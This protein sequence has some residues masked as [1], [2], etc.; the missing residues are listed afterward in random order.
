MKA[1]LVTRTC[2]S[3][4]SL[5]DH[6]PKERINS[7]TENANRKTKVLKTQPRREFLTWMENLFGNARK[8]FAYNLQSTICKIQNRCLAGRSHLTINRNGAWDPQL[9]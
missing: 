8:T 5:Q 4:L 9:T 7:C 2:V 1:S 6:M 3:F